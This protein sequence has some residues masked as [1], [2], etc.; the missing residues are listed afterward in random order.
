MADISTQVRVEQS[1][2]GGDLVGNG[3]MVAGIKRV[4]GILGGQYLFL[5]HSL[6]M[7]KEY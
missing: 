2:D 6:S 7:G 3:V 5:L 4:R 1:C